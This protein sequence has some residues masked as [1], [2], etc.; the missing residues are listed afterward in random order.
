MPREKEAYRDNLAAIQNAYP[1]K[2]VLSIKEVCEYLGACYKTV[3]GHVPGYKPG[4]GYS[5]YTLA[6]Y[7]S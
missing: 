5:I 6:R 7:L 2:N 1:G 4:V 3:K